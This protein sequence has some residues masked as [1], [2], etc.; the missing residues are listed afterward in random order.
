MSTP[1]EAEDVKLICSLF[2]RHEALIDRVIAELEE[3]FGPTDWTS[4]KLFFDR[5]RY[6]QREM[7]WPLH[8]RFLAFRRL[9]RPEHIVEIKL[10]T[11]HLENQYLK[12][13]KRDINIDPGY[14]SLER[15]ILATGKNY[16]HRIYL[17]NGIYADLTLIFQKGSFR[18]LEWTYRD[19]ADPEIITHFNELRARYKRQLRG[20]EDGSASGTG[21]K[22]LERR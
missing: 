11:D 3:M 2:S 21:S 4:P 6:Y 5:T 12:D 1:S 15:V 20:I 22:E 16:T 18:A 13:G 8:R 14:I 7:G 9:I 10:R 19:Y 17:S